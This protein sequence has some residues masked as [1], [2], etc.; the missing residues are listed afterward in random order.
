MPDLHACLDT[1]KQN[2]KTWKAYEETEKDKEIYNEKTL[3]Q[4]DVGS[5]E[6]KKEEEF[7]DSEEEE[8]KHG[9]PKSS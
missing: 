3:P 7:T 2:L 5:I 8:K 6:E 4:I 1:C 9:E